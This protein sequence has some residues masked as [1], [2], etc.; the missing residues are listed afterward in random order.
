MCL[1]SP[2]HGRDI[3]N[4]PVA[5][6]SWSTASL[7]PGSKSGLGCLITERVAVG[8]ACDG[9]ERL[10]PQQHTDG[11]SCQLTLPFLPFSQ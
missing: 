1:L 10:H 7:G 11:L 4:S 2:P 5:L 9:T 8:G 6:S 3:V